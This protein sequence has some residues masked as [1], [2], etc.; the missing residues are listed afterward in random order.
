MMKVY[1]ITGNGLHAQVHCVVSRSMEDA[2][3]AWV[4][5]YGREPQGIELYSEYVIVATEEEKEKPF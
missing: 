4:D 2:V 5:K 3:I 1:R